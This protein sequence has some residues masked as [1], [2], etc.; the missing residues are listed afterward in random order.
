MRSLIR[1]KLASFKKIIFTTN[2]PL[3]GGQKNCVDIQNLYYKTFNAHPGSK[4]LNGVC[5]PRR[6]PWEPKLGGKAIPSGGYA[7]QCAGAIQGKEGG[8]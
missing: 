4:A 6:V 1:K 2:F 8:I 5:A 3:C 7:V